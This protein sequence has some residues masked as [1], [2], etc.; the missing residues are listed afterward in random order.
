MVAYLDTS[1][2]GFSCATDGAIP[3]VTEIVRKIFGLESNPLRW[4]N[5]LAAA[6]GAG[7]QIVVLNYES[8]FALA[9]LDTERNCQ[10]VA[11]E[12]LFSR[13]LNGSL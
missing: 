9:G 5:Q 2:S 1:R 11:S 7:L 8:V 4:S 6:A 12:G 3:K 13:N 10:N